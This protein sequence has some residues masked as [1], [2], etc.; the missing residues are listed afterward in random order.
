M[1][2][3]FTLAFILMMAVFTYAQPV[4]MDGIAE[5]QKKKMPAAVIELP[6][7]AEIV[8]KAIEEKFPSPLVFLNQ[9]TT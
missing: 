7:A 3:I 5:Y 4:A 6:Y 1:K 8:E 9:A 2:G